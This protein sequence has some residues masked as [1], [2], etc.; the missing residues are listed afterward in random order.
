MNQIPSR[1]RP[2][3]SKDVRRLFPLRFEVPFLIIS[4]SL[5]SL[6]PSPLVPAS[7][8]EATRIESTQGYFIHQ[9]HED[10]HE[11]HREEES[12]R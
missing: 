3:S 5:G 2:S 7:T 4:S 8:Q 6:S 1:T 11:T 10:G 12:S 9:E